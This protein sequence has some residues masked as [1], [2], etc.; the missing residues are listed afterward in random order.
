MHVQFTK[1]THSCTHIQVTTL[2]IGLITY[3][4]KKKTERVSVIV[5]VTADLLNNDN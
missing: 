4:K 2:N 1:H 5:A 3:A